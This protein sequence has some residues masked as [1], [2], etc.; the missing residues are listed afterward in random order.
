MPALLRSLRTELRYQWWSKLLLLPLGVSV[1]GLGASFSGSISNSAFTLQRLR[2]TQSQAAAN[3]VTLEDALA[4]PINTTIQGGQKFIDNPLRADYESAYHA[5][6]TFDGLN[7]ISTGLEMITFIVLPLLFFIYG[8]AVAVNDIKQRIVKQRVSTQ[9]ST[10]YVVAKALLISGAALASVL[11]CSV[12]SVVA[13][14]A[15]KV[16]F[17]PDAASAFPY[18][19][20][21]SS[22]GNPGVQ[23]AFSAGTAIFFGLA[24]FFVSLA[25]RAILIPAL[26][27]GGLLMVAPFAGAYDPRNILSVAGA[28]VFN[29]WGGF[30]P[31]A[32]FPVSATTGLLL[33]LTGLCI[34]VAAG[35][36]V[37]SRRSKYI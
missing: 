1:L 20:E 17:Q 7:A 36:L 37:W 9:G 35:S 5:N 23:M 26:A 28:E 12:L 25:T 24:G 27:A 15:L 33:M 11:L 32:L 18:A 16:A 8:A 13:A 34:V 29:F 14:P 2:L 6:L 22:T 10:P 30:M 3:G 19:V 21:S 4:H 31:R